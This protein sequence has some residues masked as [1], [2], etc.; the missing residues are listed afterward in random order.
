MESNNPLLTRAINPSSAKSSN[1]LLVDMDGPIAELEEK[2]LIRC[3]SLFSKESLL[4]NRL[5]TT[6]QSHRFSDVCPEPYRKA[7][8]SILCE[9]GFFA[10]LSVVPGA[11][12]ALNTLIELGFDVHICTSPIKACAQNC[13]SEKTEWVL[14]NFGSDFVRR[15]I[16]TSDKTLIRGRFL[17]DDNPEVCG[18]MTPEWEHVIFDFDYNRGVNHKRRLTWENYLEVLDLTL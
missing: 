18:I 8:S 4:I 17:I 9:P 11:L 5:F 15:L 14:R 3:L 6:R 13:I 16:V 7:I 2:F 1:V 12:N 10:S